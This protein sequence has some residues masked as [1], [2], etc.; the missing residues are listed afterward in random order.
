MVRGENFPSKNDDGVSFSV[1]VVYEALNGNTTTTAVPNASGA[2]ETEIRIPTTATIPSTNVIKVS[3][4]TANGTP[5]VTTLT[6]D[7][8]EG[9]ISLSETSGSAGTSVT[10]SGEG[11]KAFVPV[12][13]V[14]VGAI[15]VTPSPRPSTDAQGMMNFDITIPGLDNGI[16]TVEVKV[17]QTTASV[18]FTVVPSGVAAGDITPSAKAVENLG[19]SFVVAWHFNNDSK[20]WTFYDGMEGSDLANFIT[21]ESYLLQVAATT[22]VILNNKTRNLT[23][24]GGNCWN[25]IVW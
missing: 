14:K 9:A 11:F 3:F 17:G 10:I 20:T 6:H 16:Q 1:Q 4:N 2:F 24:V 19:D 21:G 25:Q 8:P 22:E 23:C 12:S 15:E 5:V 18:G 13:S 7:V